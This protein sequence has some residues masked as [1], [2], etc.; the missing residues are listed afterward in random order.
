V[1][2]LKAR[3]AERD[4]DEAV[5]AAIKA[6]KITPAQREWAEKYALSDPEGFRLFV[7]KAPQVAPSGGAMPLSTGGARGIEDAQLEINKLMGLSDEAW[8]K[9]NPPQA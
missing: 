2:A 1:A 5:A 8:K 9:Y 7:A 6:G 4:R 3:M